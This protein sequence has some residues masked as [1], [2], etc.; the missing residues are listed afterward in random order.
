MSGCCFALLHADAWLQQARRKIMH[1]SQVGGRWKKKA[2]AA[3]SIRRSVGWIHTRQ[4]S[5][6][7]RRYK[8]KTKTVHLLPRA[9][10][11]PLCMGNGIAPFSFLWILGRK[12][13]RGMWKQA[14]MLKYDVT[15]SSGQKQIFRRK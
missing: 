4:Y 1:S 6:F 5:N 9:C 10:L 7:T 12:R 8:S 15:S 11:L 13:I 3:S 14:G 2:Y